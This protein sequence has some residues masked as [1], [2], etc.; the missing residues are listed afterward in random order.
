MTF[1]FGNC[2]FNHILK[3]YIDIQKSGLT[4]IELAW[5]IIYITFNVQF[6]KLTKEGLVT[7]GGVIYLESKPHG[8]VHY[9]CGTM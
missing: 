1:N 4:D 8:L 5:F 2:N 3:I 6:P 7:C 9:A